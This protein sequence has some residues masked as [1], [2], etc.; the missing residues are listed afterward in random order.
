MKKALFLDRDGIINEDTSYPHKPE[1]IVFIREVFSLCRTAIDKGYVVV[2]VTNQA[3]VA[4]G[5]FREEDIVKLHEWMILRFDAE[6][7]KI[8]AFYYCPFHPDATV[9]RY[10]KDSD[11][12]KPRPGMV[13]QA[14]EDFDIDIK[15]SIMVGDKPSDRIELPGLKCII[16]KSKYT[17]TNYDVEEL[18]QVEKLL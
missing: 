13:L 1:Q 11:C 3:G 14:V 10:R 15:E 6:G 8:S 2:V 17:G 4:K 16:V 7:V 12:R 9:E 18:S 5:Y